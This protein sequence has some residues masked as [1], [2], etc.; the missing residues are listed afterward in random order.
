MEWE[1]IW[2]MG[3]V[4][5]SCNFNFL[6]ELSMRCHLQLSTHSCGTVLIAAFLIE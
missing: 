5:V 3:V 1:G 4:S 2:G 6:H